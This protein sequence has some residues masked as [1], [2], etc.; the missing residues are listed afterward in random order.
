MC[1]KGEPAQGLPV[2]AEPA[3][4]KPFAGETDTAT[5]EVR[6]PYFAAICDD[7]FPCTTEHLD[8]ATGR[9]VYEPAVLPCAPTPC[10]DDGDCVAGQ[11]DLES[12]TCRPCEPYSPGGDWIG[13]PMA[14]SACKKDATNQTCLGHVCRLGESLK[15]KNDG[16]TNQ[17]PPGLHCRVGMSG[18]FC[19]E[20]TD[21]VQCPAGATCSGGLCL[22]NVDDQCSTLC[23]QGGLPSGCSQGKVCLKF[24]HQ[25]GCNCAPAIC[26]GKACSGGHVWDCKGDGSGFVLN[27]KR[28]CSA[29]DSDVCIDV[30][31]KP[32]VA[33]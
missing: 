20:C 21:D 4:G 18:Y 3:D 6:P 8:V 16:G 12:G 23:I 5:A 33:K 11:C 32:A 22:P 10:S 30:K 19:A 27:S 17:C 9:C 14:S 26:L 28:P 29:S 1:A 2:D 13:H 31:C 7:G 15:C 24:W 25:G